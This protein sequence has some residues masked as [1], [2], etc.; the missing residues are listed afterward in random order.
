MNGAIRRAIS[1]LRSAWAWRRYIVASPEGVWTPA[2]FLVAI[3]SIANAQTDTRIEGIVLSEG[4]KPILGVSVSGS[5]S[6]TCC[7][8]EREN[9]STDQNGTFHLEH[10]GA[11]LHVFAQGYEPQSI[12]VQPGTRNLTIRLAP[13]ANDMV[14]PDCS[15]TFRKRRRIGWGKYGLSFAVPRKGLNISGGKPDVDYVTYLIQPGNSQAKLELWFGAYAIGLEPSDEQFVNSASF[16]QRHI[17]SSKGE[18]LGVDSR[19][20]LRDGQIWR[21]AVVVAQ[22]GAEYQTSN[23]EDAAELDGIINAM[24]WIPQPAQ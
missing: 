5:K 9:T 18:L 12:V 22:G 24:C 11:V 16:S 13:M 15:R 1:L 10:P 19:G 17:L 2:L 21:H 20:Q 6:T 4:D 23:Q 14:A 8:I 7:P 3:V